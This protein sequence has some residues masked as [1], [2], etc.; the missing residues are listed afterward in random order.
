MHGFQ[1]LS[2]S[3]STCRRPFIQILLFWM[4]PIIAVP[5]YW[6]FLFGI[7]G[8]GAQVEG[9]SRSSHDC[10]A[11]KIALVKGSGCLGSLSVWPRSPKERTNDG[12]RLAQ[13][14]TESG[15]PSGWFQFLRPRV[16]VSCSCF[17]IFS[18]QIF[19]Q[20]RSFSL[21]FGSGVCFCVSV[22]FLGD[23]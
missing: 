14:P 5:S 6:V 23:H 19:K 11:Q 4:Q 8:G 13:L 12:A 1:V 18:Y 17:L 9:G 2:V 16:C 22:S 7:R 10:L 21:V 15:W 20:W 3:T